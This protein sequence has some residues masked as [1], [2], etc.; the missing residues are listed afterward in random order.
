MKKFNSQEKV[1]KFNSQEQVI[2]RKTKGD[3]VSAEQKH[4]PVPL[5]ET[6]RAKKED[7]HTC[8]I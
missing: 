8:H 6:V 3:G 1:K 5:S 4:G 7:F 2:Q